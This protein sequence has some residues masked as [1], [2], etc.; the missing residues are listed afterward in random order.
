MFDGRPVFGVQQVLRPLRHATL[1]EPDG[2]SWEGLEARRG[3]RTSA[4]TR[5]TPGP[6]MPT[7]RA[8]AVDRSRTRPRTN[9]PRSF[10]V[11]TTLRSPWVTR[12]LVPK[13]SERWAQVRAFWL[14]RWP[15]AVRLPDSLP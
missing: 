5:P 9:G 7:A 4:T 11:T 15:D 10:T 14:K 1:T 3:Y 12:S 13:G 8:A 6:G 2:L